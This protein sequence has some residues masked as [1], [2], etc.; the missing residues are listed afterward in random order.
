VPSCYKISSL[1]NS[2][3]N[4]EKLERGTLEEDFSLESALSHQKI[5]FRLNVNSDTVHYNTVHARY[6]CAYKYPRDTS[7]SA[8]EREKERDSRSRVMD[9][10]ISSGGYASAC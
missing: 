8:R 9:G 10:W 7:A 1:G 4:G 2:S 6:K 5:L 3:D